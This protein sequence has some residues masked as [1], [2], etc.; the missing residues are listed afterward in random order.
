MMC[1]YYLLLLFLLNNTQKVSNR[2][3]NHHTKD[4]WYDNLQH[5]QQ[6]WTSDRQSNRDIEAKY[7]EGS[8]DIKTSDEEIDAEYPKK[9]WMRKLRELRDDERYGDSNGE[10]TKRVTI[11]MP[12]VCVLKNN[13]VLRC[14]TIKYR[15]RGITYCW[16]QKKKICTSLDWQE[17]RQ[18]NIMQDKKLCSSMTEMKSFWEKWLLQKQSIFGFHEFT[19]DG[20]MAGLTILCDCTNQ[21]SRIYRNSRNIRQVTSLWRQHRQGE[22]HTVSNI[23]V[24]SMMS[25]L[26]SLWFRKI[27]IANLKTNCISKNYPNNI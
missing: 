5:V 24:F 17:C 21:K 2:M 25:G 14:R 4:I 15:G 6:K 7:F 11:G 27:V 23:F 26:K 12:A 3:I 19:N 13:K 18:L 1:W 10:T 8:W 16:Y 20:G 22:T 9:V